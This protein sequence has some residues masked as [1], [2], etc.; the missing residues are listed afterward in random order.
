MTTFNPGGVRRLKK[1]CFC[2]ERLEGGF[3]DK[4]VHIGLLEWRIR[5]CPYCGKKIN[6]RKGVKK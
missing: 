5:F 6:W 4:V 1:Q 3:V 2:I